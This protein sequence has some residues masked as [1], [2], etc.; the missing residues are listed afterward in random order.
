MSNSAGTNDDEGDIEAQ[1]L[2]YKTGVKV[3]RHSTKKPGCMND[4]VKYF[5][6]KPGLQDIRPSEIAIIGDRLLT[7]IMMANMMGAWSVWIK[8]GVVVQ[9]KIVSLLIYCFLM[10]LLITVYA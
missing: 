6:S 1:I 5:C 9:S 3:F 4:I 8:D 2:E 7:D 10:R